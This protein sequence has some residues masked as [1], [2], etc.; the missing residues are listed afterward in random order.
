MTIPPF[1]FWGLRTISY[2]ILGWSL[3]RGRQNEGKDLHRGNKCPFGD[4]S[5]APSENSSS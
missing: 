2:L 5:L 1:W 4:A 3:I